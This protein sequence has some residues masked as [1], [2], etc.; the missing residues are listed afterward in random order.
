MEVS[1]LTT[2]PSISIV[3]PAYN[4]AANIETAVMEAIDALSTLTD[5]FEVVVVDDGSSDQTATIANGLSEKYNEVHLVKH[6][7]NLGYGA[8]IRSGFNK[9]SKQL[10]G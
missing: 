8:A 5:D 9:S 10:I 3:L 2:R 4:E 7:S 6:R 1:S